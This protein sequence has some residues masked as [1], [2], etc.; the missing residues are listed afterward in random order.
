M[1]LHHPKHAKQKLA[2]AGGVVLQVDADGNVETDDKDHI[3]ALTTVGFTPTFARKEKAPEK[4][5]PAPQ[6]EVD[7]GEED[8]E[9]ESEET[10]TEETE[11]EEPT[12]ET[13]SE[14]PKEA[15]EPE[16]KPAHK[17]GRRR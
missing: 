17:R 7:A 15:A 12:E 16:K 11:S 3:A 1:K 4:L 6:T 9:E 2:M 5:A 13:E 8:E 14:E 10:E